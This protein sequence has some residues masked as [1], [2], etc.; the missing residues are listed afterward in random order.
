MEKLVRDKIPEI[1][2][3][4]REEKASF[5]IASREEYI[6][7][8]ARKLREEVEEYLAEKNAEELA[9]IL[10]VVYHLAEESRLNAAKLEE[11]R[12]RKLEERGGFRERKV[13]KF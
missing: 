12:R 7:L 2:S 3:R 8:L 1:V 10:E 4:D 13:M 11:M 6:E 9:D 5:R